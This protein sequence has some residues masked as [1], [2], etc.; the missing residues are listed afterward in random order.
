M[1]HSGTKYQ[2]LSRCV[3]RKRPERSI[4]ASWKFRTLNCAF[5]QPTW[6]FWHPGISTASATT[7]EL[8]GRPSRVS[9]RLA[10]TSRLEA[11][12]AVLQLERV[13]PLFNLSI[14]LRALPGG[15]NDEPGNWAIQIHSSAT[16]SRLGVREGGVRY[17]PLPSFSSERV[18]LSLVPILPTSEGEIKR[19]DFAPTKAKLLN[20]LLEAVLATLA[21]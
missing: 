3:D 7:N 18:P 11:V 10:K 4:Q 16:P 2:N 6:S 8:N 5:T 21:S 13:Q 1:S 12:N 20:Q 15:F 14:R 9:E 17:R 19:Q